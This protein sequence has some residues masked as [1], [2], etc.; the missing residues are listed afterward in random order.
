MKVPSF[1]AV[2][3]LCLMLAPAAEAACTTGRALPT[4]AG[5]ASWYGAEQGGHRTASGERFDPKDLTAAHNDLPFGTKLKVTSLATG[6]S[7][8]VR[9]NDR[10]PGYGRLV[11]LSEAAAR[12]LGTHACGLA[13]V[14]IEQV[15]QN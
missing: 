2:A 8:T 3:A 6:R 11:D 15:A 9:V 13:A 7:V 14:T 5:L 12:R 10:G 1:L 4:G